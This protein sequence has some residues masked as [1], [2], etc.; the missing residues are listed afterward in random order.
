[1]SNFYTM[2]FSMFS[3]FSRLVRSHELLYYIACLRACQQLFST[4]FRG[5]F[6]SI[7]MRA[8][9]SFYVVFCCLRLSDSLIILPKI[10]PLVNGFL[11]LFLPFFDFF[12]TWILRLFAGEQPG[13]VLPFANTCFFAFAERSSM[14]AEQGKY[15][16][17]ATHYNV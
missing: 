11:H 7:S 10:L 6:L 4:F 16:R 1:D 14:T 12:F 8:I 15:R 13:R 9:A 2:K 17:P 5:I 3:P